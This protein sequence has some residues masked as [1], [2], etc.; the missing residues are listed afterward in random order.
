MK[1]L[2]DVGLLIF[3][4]TFSVLMMTHGFHKVETLF[5]GGQF[6]SLFGLPPTVTLILAILGEFI[7]PIFII[8][9]FKT[10]IAAIP[11]TITMA[12]ATFIVHAGHTLAKKELA[13]LYFFAFFTI[14]L[15]GAG[16][17]SA[18]KK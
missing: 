7:A 5:T 12:V 3:R 18:D 14:M 15:T 11:A 2:L 1:S 8:I 9:G 6:S 4:V 13:L 16:K 10:R 17:L